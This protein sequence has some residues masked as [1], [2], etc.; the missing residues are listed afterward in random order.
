MRLIFLATALLAGCFNPKFKEQLACGANGECPPGRMCGADMLCH[1]MPNDAA[2]DVMPDAPP[3][4]CNGDAD[5]QTPPDACTVNGVCDL[6]QHLCVY[7]P[8]DCSAMTDECNNGSCDAQMGCVKVAAHE[9]VAC[10][11]GNVCGAFGACGGFANTCDASGTQSRGCTMYTCQSGTCTGN[12][13][14]DSQA[15]SRVTE[16][17]SCGS[18]TVSNCG[19][20]MNSSNSGC[21]ADGN[22]SC[23]CSTPTCMSEV[24][25]P[26]SSTCLRQTNCKTILAG[27]VCGATSAGCTA[28]LIKDI[29]CS[30]SGA[31]SSICSP[32]S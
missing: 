23:T 24:C 25:T 27:D 9:G 6:S 30:T 3:V 19:A 16:G 8:R 28:G 32:C 12:A 21:A 11:Q 17:T 29:C 14:N 18:V 20:C 7:Q 2:P 26:V 31:C 10:G 22:Q 13:Y 1:A 5:C 4:A 15:C